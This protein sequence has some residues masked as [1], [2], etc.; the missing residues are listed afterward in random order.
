MKIRLLT[1]MAGAYTFAAGQVID[2]PNPTRDMLAW[3]RPLPDGSVRAEVV[4]DEPEEAM[5]GAGEHAVVRRRRGR[6]VGS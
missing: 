2:V 6:A 1:S 3:L 5:V 4:L